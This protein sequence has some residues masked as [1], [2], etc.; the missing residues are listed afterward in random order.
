MAIVGLILG[1]F[2]ICSLV[3]YLLAMAMIWI[4]LVIF[5]ALAFVIGLAVG[6]PSLGFLLAIPATGLALW[7]YGK[8]SDAPSS[9]DGQ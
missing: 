7:A 2:A 5:F 3:V 1:L 9:T 8:F 6:D 4:I